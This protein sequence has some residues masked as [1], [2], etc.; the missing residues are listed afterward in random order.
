MHVQKDRAR[1]EALL[2]FNGKHSERASANGDVDDDD[3]LDPALQ[4]LATS[5]DTQLQALQKPSC[6]LNDCLKVGL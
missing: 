3:A 6:Q 4:D 2:Y 1:A 5:I